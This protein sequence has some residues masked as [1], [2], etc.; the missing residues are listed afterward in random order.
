M[1]FT[2]SAEPAVGSLKLSRCQDL[3]AVTVPMRPPAT[4]E[5][6]GNDVYCCIVRDL[7]TGEVGA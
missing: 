7:K 1:F 5:G 2:L 6:G 3:L 4:A